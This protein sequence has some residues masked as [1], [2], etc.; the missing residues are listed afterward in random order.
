MESVPSE[1]GLPDDQRESS[2]VPQGTAT[3]ETGAATALEK[4]R[5]QML[6]VEDNRADVFLLQEAIR[7]HGVPVDIHAVEDGAEAVAVIERA[8]KDPDAFVPRIVVLD[9]N[10]PK[11]S[12]AEVLRQI[13]DSS[14][15]KHLPVIVLT[16][17]DSSRDRAEMARLGATRYFRKPATYDEFI[18]VGT[19][20]NEVL[21]QLDRTV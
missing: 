3:H 14:R 11:K 13:R 9:L 15:F 10:L 12:G 20:L 6:L 4:P 1:N 16:S 19:V 8:E 18:E 21:A 7:T 17:S 5:M 2:V